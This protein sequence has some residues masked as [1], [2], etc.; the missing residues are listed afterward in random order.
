M[1]RTL[2]SI[3]KYD[4]LAVMLPEDMKKLDTSI[5]KIISISIMVGLSVFLILTP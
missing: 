2:L 5:W 4:I 3:G 1:K